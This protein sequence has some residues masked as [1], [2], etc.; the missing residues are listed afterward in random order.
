MKLT[1]LLAVLTAGLICAAA[2]ADSPSTGVI[3]IDNQ[4]VAAAF[5][6]GGTLIKTNNFKVMAGR[7]VEPGK[8]EI[9]EKDTDVFYITEGSATFVTGGTAV[10]PRTVAPDEI[11]AQEITGGEAHHLTKGDIII[12]PN[13]VPHQ[14]TEVNGPFLYFVVKVSK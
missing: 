11:Q 7:R 6:K 9:H 14:F 3:Q 2:A 5:A 4:A 8:V 1:L 12:I 10:Q 13:G